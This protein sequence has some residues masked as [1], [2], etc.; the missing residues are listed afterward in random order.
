MNSG[1]ERRR[2]PLSRPEALH[3]GLEARRL[4][5]RRGI[6]ETVLQRGLS[7]EDTDNMVQTPGNRPWFDRP[8]R[9]EIP[10]AGDGFHLR[11]ERFHRLD[12]LW[13]RRDG[14]YLL[15]EVKGKIG[16][17]EGLHVAEKLHH[18][19]R[20]AH[21]RDAVVRAWA[22]DWLCMRNKAWGAIAEQARLE[23]ELDAAVAGKLGRT[24]D[25]GRTSDTSPGPS[26]D[27]VVLCE[28]ISETAAGLLRDFERAWQGQVAS[29]EVWRIDQVDDDHLVVE[30]TDFSAL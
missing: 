3:V 23:A 29:A 24:W 15:L 8:E 17:G 19:M 16:K 5:G 25:L 7:V 18:W 4:A 27:I 10:G 28:R 20:L 12:G 26:P 9:Y 2:I 30:V 21:G 6:G 13:R 22:L 14:S 11:G 1:R